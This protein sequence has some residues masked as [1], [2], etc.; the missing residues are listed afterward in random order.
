MLRARRMLLGA[1]AVAALSLAGFVP[2][3]AAGTAAE[4][5]ADGGGSARLAV[6]GI[7]PIIVAS[8]V[9]TPMTITGVDF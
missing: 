9:A 8:G 2:S 5:G 6:T 7:S 1:I 3:A 4:L